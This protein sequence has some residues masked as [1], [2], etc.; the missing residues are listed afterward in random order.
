MCV[1]CVSAFY[2]VGLAEPLDHGHTQG[3]EWE[4]VHKGRCNAHKYAKPCQSPADDF[5]FVRLNVLR[6]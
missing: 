5:G 6:L 2:L 3:H 4:V 1:L